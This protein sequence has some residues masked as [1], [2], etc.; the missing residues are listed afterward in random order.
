MVGST[1]Q[2][3][4][5]LAV[6]AI[7]WLGALAVT[8]GFE[9]AHPG[10]VPNLVGA[11]F[12]G[13]EQRFGVWSSAL[14]AN[15]TTMT[16]TGAVDSF[17]DSFTAL[18]GGMLLLNMLL[19]EVSPGGV[20]SGLYGMLVLAVLAVFVGGLMVGRTPEYLGKKI[21]QREIT[22]VALYVLAMPFAV[23]VGSALALAF[24]GPR[25]T[26]LNPGSHGLSEVLYAFA[27]ASNNNGSA[28]A[29]LGVGT[30][31]YN[32]A[33]GVA[34][35]IGRFLPIV[36]VLAL[37]G[38]LARQQ[39]VPV[40]DGTLSTSK[41]LFVGLLAGVVLIVAG[42]TFFPALALGPIAEGLR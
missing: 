2:G 3:L 21:R 42:L 25:E 19:G 22:L 26:I 17:H 33:L 31:F 10:T 20:G 14:W 32:T 40:T 36:L 38:S 28:F 29:G 15:S 13:K 7:L 37:A 35:L 27:S 30:P 23:L 12:E 11:S 24:P 18:G 6:M 39:P 5:I 1:K 41:P 8:I 16:S 34:M 9:V 4:A